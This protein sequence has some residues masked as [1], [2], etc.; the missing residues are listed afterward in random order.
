MFQDPRKGRLLRASSA[1]TSSPG[2]RQTLRF[3]YASQW[4]IEVKRRRH[5]S[6]RATV[7]RDR[8]IGAMTCKPVT[9]S[10][11]TAM[12]TAYARAR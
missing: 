5:D 3:A 1:T 6:H 4:I 12:R 11:S 8:V 10:L 9:Q 7:S 2:K